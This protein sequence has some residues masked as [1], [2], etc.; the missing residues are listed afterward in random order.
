[1]AVAAAPTPIPAFAPVDM[2]E[3]LELLELLE[4]SVTGM[5]AISVG[6]LELVAFGGEDV[7]EPDKGVGFEE[8][9]NELVPWRED[10]VT[11]DCFEVEGL[12]LGFCIE[13][14]TI[15]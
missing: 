9:S 14:M 15:V 5:R 6:E 7:G 10:A 11:V 12:G 4:E 2:P 8:T 1:M 3:L 13:R